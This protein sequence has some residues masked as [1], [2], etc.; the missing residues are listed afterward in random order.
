[1]VM[2]EIWA[3]GGKELVRLISERIE[4]DGR[5]EKNPSCVASGKAGRLDVS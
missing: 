5:S 1:M 3:C 4:S 2:T